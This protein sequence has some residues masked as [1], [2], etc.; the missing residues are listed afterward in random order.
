MYLCREEEGRDLLGKRT[1]DFKV[2]YLDGG[3]GAMTDRS[4]LLSDSDFV[5]RCQRSRRYKTQVRDH[6]GGVTTLPTTG[7]HG[8]HPGHQ[9]TPVTGSRTNA[10]RI[11]AGSDGTP[12]SDGRYS[13]PFSD[14]STSGNS[15]VAATAMTT[16]DGRMSGAIAYPHHSPHAGTVGTP[17]VGT[18]AASVY[19]PY[20]SDHHHSGKM[21]S[22]GSDF[23][24][25]HALDRSSH[26]HHHSPH[27]GSAVVPSVQSVAGTLYPYNGVTSDTSS[28]TSYAAANLFTAA[29]DHTNPRSFL[30]G[31]FLHSYRHAAA[32]GTYYPEYHG[33]VSSA[34]AY[35]AAN[36]FLSD[37]DPASN[38][39]TGN[40]HRSYFPVS[41][42]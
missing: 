19:S 9:I 2:T 20:S 4:G 10:K 11:K 16:M 24:S 27:S 15:I 32:L 25:Y 28:L 39:R 21:F 18:T 7:Q 1:M 35:S 6:V 33:S 36:G 31:D 23:S 14:H 41:L 5:M 22:N 30:T 34:A 12:D 38:F 42:Q 8:T 26:Y 3:L 37:K 13:L 29:M 40:D 17:S